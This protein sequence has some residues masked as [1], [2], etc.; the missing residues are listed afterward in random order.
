MAPG[1]TDLFPNFSVPGVFAQRGSPPNNASQ[2]RTSDA[3][4]LD[5]ALDRADVN[6]FHHLIHG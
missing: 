1:D 3:V 5:N 4:T 6:H 2:A